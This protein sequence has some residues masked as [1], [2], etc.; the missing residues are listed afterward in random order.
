[1]KQ[2]YAVLLIVSI[3]CLFASCMGLEHDNIEGVSPFQPTYALPIGVS[4]L[5]YEDS[6]EIPYDD[7]LKDVLF[8]L[9][10]KDTLHV[11][12]SNS[13]FPIDNII[14]LTLHLYT[15]NTFP[16]DVEVAVYSQVS[17]VFFLTLTNNTIVI[18]A[19]TVD[20]NGKVLLSQIQIDDV[21]VSH[22]E[23]FFQ[24][25]QFFITMKVK[26]VLYTPELL[27]NIANYS[28]STDFGFKINLQL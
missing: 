27:N 2:S 5:H 7:R 6:A 15:V 24:T 11:D 21:E 14:S 8:D 17:S 13:L 25:T 4:Q 28:V 23:D 20:E 22:I 10:Y 12:M 26:D 1:M 19:A 9:E 18:P 3:I 16:F